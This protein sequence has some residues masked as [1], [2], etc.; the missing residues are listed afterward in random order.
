MKRKPSV[1]YIN[2]EEFY[3]RLVEWRN[4]GEEKI[5]DDIALC[6][7]KICNNLARNAK[8]SGYTWKDEMIGDALYSCIRFVRNFDP[9][10]SKNPFA[11]F[12]QIAY[13]SFAKR[14][15]IEN[16]KLATLA[17][18]KEEIAVIYGLQDESDDDDN[19]YGNIE[20]TAKRI[21]RTYIKHPKKTKQK[22]QAQT[23]ND[24][25]VFC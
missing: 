22:Q 20:N 4:S 16:Q 10:K 15:G 7:M 2:N 8:F 11:F 25:D 3:N 19:R 9:E 12:S 1:N 6:L 13:N 14:I 21:N 23:G 24:I 5:P 18:Y 17:E